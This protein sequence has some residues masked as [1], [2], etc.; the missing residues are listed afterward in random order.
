MTELDKDQQADQRPKK[1]LW[2]GYG[3]YG[4]GNPTTQIGGGNV[5]DPS[6]IENLSKNTNTC[7]IVAVIVLVGLPVLAM[8][9]AWVTSL[10]AR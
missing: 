10:I 4:G 8:L 6:L 9:L 5:R 1:Y 7:S 2:F 3:N